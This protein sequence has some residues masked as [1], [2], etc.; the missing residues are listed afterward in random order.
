MNYDDKIEKMA[1]AIHESWM[2]SRNTMM[3][4]YGTGTRQLVKDEKTGEITPTGKTMAKHFVPNMVSYYDL[5]DD[6]KEYD[7]MEARIALAMA[8]ALPP[9]MTELDRQSFRLCVKT[10]KTYTDTNRSPMHPGE[11]RVKCFIDNGFQCKPGDWR[12]NKCFPSFWKDRI[13]V[14]EKDLA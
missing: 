11:A 3:K 13:D 6:T 9:Y 10:S 4:K 5:G 1:V 7:R 2:R 8:G 12:Q 14:P